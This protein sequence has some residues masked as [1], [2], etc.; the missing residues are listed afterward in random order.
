[1]MASPGILK[2]ITAVLVDIDGTLWRGKQPLPGLNPFF[3]FLKAHH[4]AFTVATNNSQ[5]PA[6]LYQKRLAGY[7]VQLGL[8]NILTASW[9][10]ADYLKG[11]LEPGSGVYF[12]GQEGL[13]E[14]LEEN[15]FKILPDARQD[16]AA[17]VVGGDPGLTYDKLKHATLLIQR[18]ALFIGT[19]PDVLF[20]TEEG[21]VP[22][23]G[24]NLAAV[25]AA[26]GVVPT[27]IGKPNRYFFELGM[28][29][30]G[31]AAANT[32]M[33][34]DRL[35]TDIAGSQAAGLKGILVTTGV[36]N[37]NTIPVKNIQPDLLVHSLL[38]LVECWEMEL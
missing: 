10:T 23:C 37:E 13:R 12:I 30:M 1:M 11:R 3:N 14:A 18:E 17:V 32:A 24:T 21:L 7:G 29:R 22:E 38:E 25:Q 33:I 6:T 16:A 34:G 19:N 26:T 20:P 27:V 9:A 8:E 31:S 36:D 15:G 35:E 28:A 5:E 4:I 2:N